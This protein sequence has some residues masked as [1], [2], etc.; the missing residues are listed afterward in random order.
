MHDDP[1]L[2]TLRNRGSRMTI[3]AMLLVMLAARF[4]QIGS[5]QS[6]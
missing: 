3:L 4:V 5:G 1:L 6:D 2:F